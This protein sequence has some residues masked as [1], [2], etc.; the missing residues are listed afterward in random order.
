MKKKNGVTK[1]TWD[2]KVRVF[3]RESTSAWRDLE[4][5]VKAHCGKK[6]EKARMAMMDELCPIVDKYVDINCKIRDWC[7]KNG[8][9]IGEFICDVDNLGFDCM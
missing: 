4:A 2:K 3:A 6:T 9:D 5:F 8:V 7:H 1:R